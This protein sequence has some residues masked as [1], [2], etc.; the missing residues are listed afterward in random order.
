ML[1]LNEPYRFRMVTVGVMVGLGV[2]TTYAFSQFT[3]PMKKKYG[4]DQADITTISTVA[5]CVGYC[6][7][8]LGIIF[9]LFGPKVQLLFSGA[10]ASVGILL[11][12]LTLDGKINASS[13][14][15][16][17]AL[18]CL[19]YAIFYLGCPSMDGASIM[20][21]MM[22]F[23]LDRGYMVIIQKTFSGLGTSVLS[24]YFQAWFSDS[25]NTGS[26]K[27]AEFAY[28]LSVHVMV[29]A[30]VGALFIELPTYAPCDMVRRRLTEEELEERRAT[31]KIYMT[32]SPPRR[33]IYMGVAIVIAL[34]I[35][36]TVISLVGPYVKISLNSYRLTWAIVIVLLFSFAL[37]SLPFQCLGAYPVPDHDTKYPAIGEIDTELQ[38]VDEADAIQ[39]PVEEAEAEEDDTPVVAMVDPQ[40]KG[41]F[42]PHLLTPDLWLLWLCFFSMWGTGTVLIFNAAQIYRSKNWGEYGSSKM[43]LYISI[44]G[45]GSAIGRIASGTI[46]MIVSRRRARGEKGLYTTLFLPLSSILLGLCFFIM[47]IIPG[48]GIIVSFLLG[49]IGNGMGWGLGALCVRI[50][51]ADDIGKHYNFMWSS[52]IV[53]TIALNRFMFGDMMDNE[54]RKQGTL[55]LCNVPACV[56]KQMWILMAC[57]I[58]STCAAVGVHWRFSR[59]SNAELARMKSE[60]EQLTQGENDSNSGE[61]SKKGLNK[62]KVSF[63][64]DGEA[65]LPAGSFKEVIC[66]YKPKKKQRLEIAWLVAVGPYHI[67][68]SLKGEGEKALHPAP[69]SLKRRCPIEND[70]ARTTI[71][72]HSTSPYPARKLKDSDNNKNVTLN[73]V[74]LNSGARRLIECLQTKLNQKGPLNNNLASTCLSFSSSRFTCTMIPLCLALLVIHSL[75]RLTATLQLP[76]PPALR[77]VFFSFPDRKTFSPFCIVGSS[78]SAMLSAPNFRF[79]SFPLLSDAWGPAAPPAEVPVSPSSPL[80]TMASSPHVGPSLS[81]KWFGRS[82]SP[83]LSLSSSGSGIFTEPKADQRVMMDVSITLLEREDTLCPLLFLSFSLFYLSH[84]H[85]ICYSFVWGGRGVV[86]FP[87]HDSGGRASLHTDRRHSQRLSPFF[88]EKRKAKNQFVV[89]SSIPLYYPLSSSTDDDNDDDDNNNNRKKNGWDTR[90]NRHHHNIREMKR[91]QKCKSLSLRVPVFMGSLGVSNCLLPSLSSTG[92]N[93]NN[94][95]NNNKNKN[96]NNGKKIDAKCRGKV[97]RSRTNFGRPVDEKISLSSLVA[98]I[99]RTECTHTTPIS[100]HGRAG[101]SDSHPSWPEWMG[102]S[103]VVLT[104]LSLASADTPLIHSAIFDFTLFPN[105]VLCVQTSRTAI[106]MG[107]LVSCRIGLRRLRFKYSYPL[108]CTRCTLK[109]LEIAILLLSFRRGKGRSGDADEF[110]Y[111]RRRRTLGGTQHQQQKLL[112]LL[113]CRLPMADRNK[114]QGPV[115]SRYEE[116]LLAFALLSMLS[117]PSAGGAPPTTQSPFENAPKAKKPV[118]AEGEAPNVIQAP[119]PVFCAQWVDDTHVLLGAGGGSRYGMANMMALVEVDSRAMHTR[120]GKHG[121][122]TAPGSPP[123]PPLW[124]LVDHLLLE[125][126]PWCCTPLLPFNAVEDTADWP[127]ERQA[128]ACET[129]PGASALG[130]DGAVMGFVA[131]SGSASFSLIA[132]HHNTAIAGGERKYRLH[133]RAV[134]RLPEDKT[135]ADKKSIALLRNLVVV[136]HDMGDVLLFSLASL[137]TPRDPAAAAAAAAAAQAR[138]TSGGKCNE[139][140]NESRADVF[141]V[142]T[143]AVPLARWRLGHRVN[144]LHANRMEMVVVSTNQGT[145][146]KT[147]HLLDYVVVAALVQDKTVRVASFRLRG[148]EKKG[149][150]SKR[151]PP[152]GGEEGWEAE[153]DVPHMVE[154]AC[155]S[156]SHFRLNFKLMTS[157]LRLVRLFGL[158]NVPKELAEASRVQRME[159]RLAAAMEQEKRVEPLEA[160]DLAGAASG[161]RAVELV[162]QQD[163]VGMVLVAYDPHDRCSF[164]VEAQMD[165]VLVPP[166]SAAGTSSPGAAGGK[167]DAVAESKYGSLQLSVRLVRQPA[168]V[169]EDD[170]ISFLCPFHST[171]ERPKFPKAKWT[172]QRDGARSGLSSAASSTTSSGA[173]RSRAH[174]ATPPPA[175]PASPAGP[176]RRMTVRQEEVIKRCVLAYRQYA[177]LGSYIPREWIVCTVDGRVVMI[178]DQLVPPSTST[179]IVPPPPELASPTMLTAVAS[180]PPMKARVLANI[181]PAL[182]TNAATCVAVSPKNDV[183]TTD[184]A[185]RIVITL[186]KP[187]LPVGDDAGEASGSQGTITA[188][189]RR[190]ASRLGLEKRQG[191][192]L[193]PP[194]DQWV[195]ALC[196]AHYW[197]TV[198]LRFR[199]ALGVLVFLFSIVCFCMN[200]W[201]DSE[202]VDLHVGCFS[203]NPITTKEIT[204]KKLEE[205]KAKLLGVEMLTKIA[206]SSCVYPVSSPSLF[207]FAPCSLSYSYNIIHMFQLR[208]DPVLQRTLSILVRSCSSSASHINMAKDSPKTKMI[209]HKQR[210]LSIL[211]RSCSSSASHINMAKDSPKTKMIIHKKTARCSLLLHFSPS[212]S[213]S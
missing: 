48:K 59:F 188:P 3:E 114:I 211:V 160:D 12:G 94:N 57:N 97:K 187:P 65:P 58:M 186:M 76:P 170:T 17:L 121:K 89:S 204:N 126:I 190:M 163:V 116:G 14:E 23:P 148:R 30:C 15:G 69:L 16:N 53:A 124:R 50:M 13:K 141:R 132:I 18:F 108:A 142:T 54:A 205:E 158:E 115:Q 47:A 173:V 144:D 192:D 66:L 98:E 134:I 110:L 101:G 11:V 96:N 180:R 152:P 28:F 2:S 24:Q 127:A 184:I 122:P 85:I 67:H 193:F 72:S 79:P 138:S 55:P 68:A 156:G 146:E 91:M 206:P 26:V 183:V 113:V 136:S 71:L 60:R 83:Q 77:F 199:V 80:C 10:L 139:D 35:H 157:S 29:C 104:L 178:Q 150:K 109:S 45:V 64:G 52:G 8:L 92:E 197:L 111:I 168:R 213:L 181:F 42:W 90:T 165:A 175:G 7:F 161:P 153:E 130:P 75:P 171:E 38:P 19:F 196:Y 93:N 174:A 151:R 209:I 201:F 145:G 33:R 106:H 32:Q 179:S 100:F 159:E 123:L 51:Y 34:L 198:A 210:T 167:G 135:N 86:A 200:F 166:S 102:F 117:A 129:S 169:V 119:F 9:D 194:D 131:V 189:D 44:I 61:E 162:A 21:L 27:N 39:E 95:N 147:V 22:N 1:V 63:E 140:G 125:D 176:R 103:L 74:E 78:H 107:L 6:A 177:V 82:S 185:Q 203:N 36:L 191:F 128:A 118:I 87:K 43:S 172:K 154:Q 4:F 49:S 155:L 84:S 182:H 20:P 208:A 41:S 62:K 88:T 37:L 105:N 133:R 81:S 31:L 202:K 195:L 149:K 99:E 207:L 56:T 73:I 112:L 212:L 164:M 40:Y 70:K 5:N 143:D 137:L 25:G 46:D 120:L